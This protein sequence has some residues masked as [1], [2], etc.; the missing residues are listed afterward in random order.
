LTNRE[1][2]RTPKTSPAGDVAGSVVRQDVA[3]VGKAGGHD[4]GGDGHRAG[5]LDQGNVITGIR[6]IKRFSTTRISS[7]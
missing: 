1:V 3:R 5:Q 4:A 6:H 7:L 2:K